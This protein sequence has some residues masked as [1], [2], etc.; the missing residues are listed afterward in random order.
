MD[1]IRERERREGLNPIERSLL[2]NFFWSFH[3]SQGENDLQI[4]LFIHSAGQYK[5]QEVGDI[6]KLEE[7]MLPHLEKFSVP[8]EHTKTVLDSRTGESYLVNDRDSDLFLHQLR[9]PLVN[10]MT[11]FYRIYYN[12]SNPDDM[13]WNQYVS[14]TS[15]LTHDELLHNIVANMLDQ[16][17]EYQQKPRP[18]RKDGSDPHA[19]HL[20]MYLFAGNTLQTLELEKLY[21][22]IGMFLAQHEVI[23]TEE[24]AL[25]NTNEGNVVKEDKYQPLR[26]RFQSL[27][28]AWQLSHPGRQFTAGS[29]I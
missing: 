7:R 9:A 16:D 4:K 5:K 13:D 14:S 1:K 26:D 10:L 27:L 28:F 19:S 12:L 23:S 24:I 29:K 25:P 22:D 3:H 8:E 15:I 11:V 20:Q 21:E 2:G 18:N 6:K 17:L